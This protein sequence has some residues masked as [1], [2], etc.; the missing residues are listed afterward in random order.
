MKSP[1]LLRL[2]EV[3]SR[4]PLSKSTVLRKV[5]DGSFPRPVR[6]GERRVA[7]VENEIIEWEQERIEERDTDNTGKAA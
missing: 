7:W 4:V 2:P 1:N 6:L 5:A 3:L